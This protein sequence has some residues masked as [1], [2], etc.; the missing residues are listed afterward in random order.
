MSEADQALLVAVGAIFVSV[1]VYAGAILRDRAL[2]RRTVEREQ[3]WRAE[4][5]REAAIA[6]IV[7]EYNNLVR[8][9]GAGASLDTVRDAGIAQLQSDEEVRTA[10]DRMSAGGQDPMG[11]YRN[12]ASI[13]GLDL[14][15]VF[16]YSVSQKIPIGRA[17]D[18]M[19]TEK[20]D[21]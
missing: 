17:I 11:A 9:T 4:D 15:A 5:T 13:E 18:A 6:A 3:S 7:Q 8:Q 16:R 2:E 20:H 21:R 14:L 12:H 19:Y 1:L 10:I